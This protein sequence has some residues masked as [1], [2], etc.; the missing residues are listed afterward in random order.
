MFSLVYKTV[1]QRPTYCSCADN[2]GKCMNIWCIKNLVIN[3]AEV[4]DNCGTHLRLLH[5]YVIKSD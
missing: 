1:C 5:V 2:L 4:S 3:I